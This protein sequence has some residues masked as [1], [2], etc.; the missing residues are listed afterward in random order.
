MQEDKKIE[1]IENF[2]IEREDGRV[3]AHKYIGQDIDIVI[4]EEITD[5][6]YEAFA[7]YGEKKQYRSLYINSKIKEPIRDNCFENFYVDENNPYMCSV[8]GVLYS[9]D[10]KKLLHY[11]S[12]SKREVYYVL[13]SVEEI[14][15]PAFRYCSLVELI[16]NDGLKKN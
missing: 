9:K 5:I 15:F 2:E 10:K 3:F 4:P 8:D 6:K 12:L 13:D 11:P 14:H 16:L 7:A 1:I